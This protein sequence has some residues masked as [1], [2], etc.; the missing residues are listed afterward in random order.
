MK[1]RNDLWLIMLLFALAGAP[2]NAQTVPISVHVRPELSQTDYCLAEDLCR[3]CWS[4][5]QTPLNENVLQHRG[6]CD[7]ALD[8]QAPLWDHLLSYILAHDPAR[9]RIDTLFWGRL[10]SEKD[11][12]RLEMAYRLSLA[13]SRSSDWNANTGGPRKDGLNAFVRHLANSANIYPELKKLFA[14]HGL[15]LIVNGVEK[16]MVLPANRL[17]Y[18]DRLKNKGVA[19]KEKLPFDCLIWFKIESTTAH[20]ERNRPHEP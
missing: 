18:Y 7:R 5:H 8:L 1:I 3:I 10:V 4:T 13:A 15:S 19:P 20:T 6:D 16:V 2:I 9:G 11:P 14:G 12:N 17:P